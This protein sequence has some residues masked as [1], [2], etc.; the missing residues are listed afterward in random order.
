VRRWAGRTSADPDQ[1]WDDLQHYLPRHREL[2]ALRSDGDGR[3]RWTV[4]D[5]AVL[6]A[7]RDGG[8]GVRAV[9]RPDALLDL[10]EQLV[11]EVDAARAA[12]VPT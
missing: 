12:A 8:V 6:D 5:S 2:L 3:G 1:T 10:L 4:T 7:W 11:Q 9:L